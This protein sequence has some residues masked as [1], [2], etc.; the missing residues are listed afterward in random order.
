M[1]FSIVSAESLAAAIVVHTVEEAVSFPDYQRRI[2]LQPLN[3]TV[4]VL[5]DNILVFVLLTVAPHV[6]K[7]WWKGVHATLASV[8][9]L[10]PLADHVYFS[11][12]FGVLRP[13]SVSA[14]ACLLPLGGLTF[15]YEAGCRSHIAGVAF[16]VLI[17]FFLHNEVRKMLEKL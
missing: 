1:R 7:R 5:L 14:I 13:G 4:E 8:A 15:V 12:K 3:T 17:T 16:G 6:Q 9:L 11:A 10:H 2:R